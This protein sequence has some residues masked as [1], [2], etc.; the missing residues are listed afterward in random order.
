MNSLLEDTPY[1]EWQDLYTHTGVEDRQR[2][3]QPKFSTSLK[4]RVETV[5]P[6]QEEKLGQLS[7]EAQRERV[8]QLDWLDGQEAI[9][10]IDAEFQ[11]IQQ[12]QPWRWCN[13][14]NLKRLW[15]G[16]KQAALN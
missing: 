13:L 2:L 4:L 9:A 7:I 10:I 5:Q 1:R 14:L 8:E 11:A 15:Q 12:K 16:G 6:A 3:P